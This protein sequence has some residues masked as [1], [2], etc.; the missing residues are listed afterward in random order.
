MRVLIVDDNAG[1]RRTIRD[2]LEDLDPDVD[3]CAD[4]DEVL[5]RFEAFLPD[6]VLMDVRM[7]RVDG[8][9][10]TARLCASHPGARVIV[11]SDHDHDDMRRAARRAGAVGYVAKRD[12]LELPRLLAGG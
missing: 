6:W 11:V 3:E 4:G 12:L 5:A 9:A 8:I 1:M 7:P 2:V 10:A